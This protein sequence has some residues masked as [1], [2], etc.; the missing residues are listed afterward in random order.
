MPRKRTPKRRPAPK[1]QQSTSDAPII[2]GLQFEDEGETFFYSVVANKSYYKW[3]GDGWKNESAENYQQ[4]DPDFLPELED[5][6][7]K[8][9][10]TA[11]KGLKKNVALMDGSMLPRLGSWLNLS[12]L[13]TPEDY[14]R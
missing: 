8:E 14:E 9:L 13:V 3:D 12:E 1:K 6:D 4:F 7:V 5:M 10:K 11:G 2:L